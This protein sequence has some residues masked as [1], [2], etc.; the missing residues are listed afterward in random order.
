LREFDEEYIVIAVD[1]EINLR[2]LRTVVDLT[3]AW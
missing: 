1:G 3:F 2:A